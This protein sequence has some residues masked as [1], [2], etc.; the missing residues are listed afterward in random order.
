MRPP[1]SRRRRV[2]RRHPAPEHQAERQRGD[3]EEDAEPQERLP[4]SD[5]LVEVPEHRRPDRAADALPGRDQAD[6]QAA[7]ALEPAHRV[8]GQRAVNGRVA[9]QPHHRAVNEV[10]LPLGVDRAGKHRA[11]AHHGHAEQGHRAR[12]GT[13]EPVAHSDAADPGADEEERVGEGRHGARPVEIARDLLQAHHQ[14]EHAAAGDHYQV[15][16]DNE[17]CDA[18]D[19][20]LRP[21]VGCERASH[22]GTQLSRLPCR[23][24]L[25]QLRTSGQGPSHSRPG[26]A[27]R[28]ALL[29]SRVGVLLPTYN[30]AWPDDDMTTK[31]KVAR[32]DLSLSNLATTDHKREFT[33]QQIGFLNLFCPE[34]RAPSFPSAPPAQTENVR[35]E[36][37]KKVVQTSRPIKTYNCWVNILSVQLMT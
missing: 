13:V 33:D 14:Q 35:K 15:S 12:S 2:P 28:P 22:F 32:R 17:H 25:H 1:S 3:Q 18:E 37:M 4:P 7:P 20:P 23:P 30:S 29:R 27:S 8:D 16:G 36:A 5:R 26:L 19:S 10:Q 9:E 31:E 24:E 34:L 21:R 6:R 11:G